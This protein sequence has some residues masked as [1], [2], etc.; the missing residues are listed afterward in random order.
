MNQLTRQLW[1]RFAAIASP[2][3]LSEA[4][5]TAWTLLVLLILLMLGQVGSEVLFNQQSGELMSALAAKDPGRFWRTIYECLAMLV[6]AVPIYAFYL[7]VRDKLGNCWRRWLTRRILHRYFHNRAYYELNS[8]AKIDNPDQRIAEDIGTFTQKSLYFL[9]IILGSLIQVAAFSGV[10]WSISRP[11]VYFL[12][13]YAVV[14]TLVTGLLFGRVLIGL[15]FLQLKKEADFRFGLVRIREN[16]ESIALYRGEDQELSQVERRFDLVFQNTTKLIRTQLLLNLF[17]YAY[18]FLT[19]VIPS[20]IIANHVL[21]GELEVGRAVQA[22]GAFT[23]ILTALAIIVNKFDELSRFAAGIDRLDT[24]V[25]FLEIE[26]PRQIANRQIAVVRGKELVIDR[27]SLLTLDEKRWIVRGLSAEVKPGEGLIIM[28]PSGSGKSSLLR[29]IAGLAGSGRGT[30]IRPG[31][32]HMLFLP[33]RPYMVLGSLRNQLLY[34]FTNQYYFDEDLLEMLERVNLP[35][36]ADHF[37]GLDADADWANVLSIGEQQRLAFA[38]VLIT[39]PRYAML[40]EA[41]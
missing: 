3:W 8:D 17:S 15:N 39:Q 2:Y 18:T 25:K 23:A 22:T 36:L 35:R 13:I 28:G 21:S 30:I 16:A 12:I 31:L 29:A 1:R 20:A 33:Q 14:G 26:A 32:K 5:R 27:L 19:I 10:L 4:K 9:L 24:F 41:T 40:D 37:G 11:L 7:F 38:R 6:V 34:P